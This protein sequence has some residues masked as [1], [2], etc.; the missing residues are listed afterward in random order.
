MLFFSVLHSSALF[1]WGLAGHAIAAFVLPTLNITTFAKESKT[2]ARA[3]IAFFNHPSHWLLFNS[4]L[5]AFLRWAH[6]GV[7]QL[8]AASHHYNSSEHNIPLHFVY[9]HYSVLLVGYS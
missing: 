8:H 7:H 4:I 9:I 1:A 2:K 6:S 3:A 5:A